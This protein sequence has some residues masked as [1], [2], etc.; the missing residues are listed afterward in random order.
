MRKKG[1]TLI[2]LLAV[3]VILAVIALISTPIII[4]VIDK[5]RKGAF[6]DSAY[7][8][9]DAAKLYFTS[10]LADNNSFSY[11]E[12]D[13]G[14]DMKDFSLSG[15]KPYGGS[16]IIN[17]DGEQALAIYDKDKKWCATKNFTEEKIRIIE[18]Y[19]KCDKDVAENLFINGY[20]EYDTNENFEDFILNNGEFS[21]TIGISPGNTGAIVSGNYIPIDSNKKYKQT[22][23]S[24]VSQIGDNIVIGMGFMAY[25]IDKK[26]IS[27]A[28][29][30][31]I[32]GTTTYLTRELKRG[33]TKVYLNDASHFVDSNMSYHRG[34]VFWNYK[35]STG[36]LYP[37]ET[38]SQNSYYNLFENSGIDRVNH[39]ITLK[40]PWNHNAVKEGTYLSQST[41][42]STNN[43]GLVNKKL[44]NAG[45]LGLAY[46]QF[47][48]EI[49]GVLK[50]NINEFTKFREGTRY[51]R[52]LYYVQNTGTARQEITLSF[53]NITFTEIP[54]S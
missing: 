46:S 23:E 16:L 40:E 35:D 43:Y 30:A 38:Y 28:T 25:D 31:F 36:H 21:D 45:S 44:G 37:V 11:T 32:S 14:G 1:F 24:K 50:N 10:K 47:D 20:G 41:D 5:A 2:E 26:H 48:N 17:D 3:I 49:E 52:F 29:A 18:N 9:L 19:T 39:I 54:N 6:E 27:P 8:V 22:V 15:E 42:G 12:I 4:G 13:F 53:K 34:F 7:G 51:V 33:D